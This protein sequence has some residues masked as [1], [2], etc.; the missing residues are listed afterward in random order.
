[1]KSIAVRSSL[2]FVVLGIIASAAIAGD[3]MMWQ[4]TTA[5][6]GAP[7]PPG[8]WEAQASY[9]VN[10]GGLAPGNV[11]LAPSS[12]IY[13]DYSTSTQNVAGGQTNVSSSPT[14]SNGG[15]VYVSTTQDPA[16]SGSATQN[17][18]ST[19][20][21]VSATQGTGSSLTTATSTNGPK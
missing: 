5:A 6:G 9:R 21:S 18:S 11:T 20:V 1:M 7:V 2:L 16:F 12:A 3:L 10:G 4:P 8:Y 14:L 19:G 13:N 17:N 15:S